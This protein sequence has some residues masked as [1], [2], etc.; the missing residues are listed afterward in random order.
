MESWRTVIWEADSDELQTGFCCFLR[1]FRPETSIGGVSRSIYST[2]SRLMAEDMS[3]RN[4]NVYVRV[5]KIY[6]LNG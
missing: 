3:L 5:I 6:N 2:G 1:R 4:Y